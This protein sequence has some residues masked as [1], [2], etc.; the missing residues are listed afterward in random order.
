MA[1]YDSIQ[2][3]YIKNFNRQAIGEANLF[4]EHRLTLN[5][6]SNGRPKYCDNFC[7]ENDK[8]F[9]GDFYCFN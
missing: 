9:S 5:L 6:Y 4:L 1:R 3:D 2:C 7:W 8:E